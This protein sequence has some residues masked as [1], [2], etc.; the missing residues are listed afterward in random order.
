M[1]ST[2]VLIKPDGINRGLI[3]KIISIYEEKGLT[4]SQMK[5]LKPERDLMSKHYVNLKEQPFFEK[6]VQYMS[7]NYCIA[8]VIS[9]KDAVSVVRRLNGA[10]NPLQA[11][12]ASIRGRFAIEVGRNLVHGSEDKENAQ[13]EI[14]LWFGGQVGRESQNPWVHEE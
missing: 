7:E 9:G 3:G 11:D 14:D 8:M 5:M 12:L 13:K 10:T 2:F 4:V 1:E 6:V